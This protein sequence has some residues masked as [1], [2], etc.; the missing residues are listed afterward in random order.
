[1]TTVARTFWATVGVFVLLSQACTAEEVPPRREQYLLLNAPYVHQSQ[2]VLRYAHDKFAEA[3]RRSTLKVGVSIIYSPADKVD[4]SVRRLQTDLQL[5]RKLKVPVLIQVDTENWLPESLLNWYDPQKPGFDP[6]KVADVEWYGWTPDTAVKVCWRNW[7][8]PIRVGPHPNL[9]SPRFQAWEK[10]IYQAM[11]PVVVQWVRELPAEDQWLFVGWKC[12]WE[13]MP[14]NQYRYFRDGNSYYSRPDNPEWNDT[15]IQHI[16][17]NAARTAGIQT[18]GELGHSQLMKVVGRHLAFLSS[19]ARELGLP[20]EKLYSHSLTQE[21]DSD[22]LDVQFNS[23]SNPSP[24]YYGSSRN[25]LR[26][27]ASFMKCV[28]KAKAELGVTGY[29]Y[30]EFRLGETDHATWYR[31]FREELLADPDCVFHALYNFDTLQGQAPI[32]Q[33]LLDAM[34]TSPVAPQR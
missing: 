32:E 16:G 31:W 13:T 2:D 8:T 27:N 6:A 24:S 1:M 9:L 7:G 30:G 4:E 20:R 3:S 28:K 19:T 26:S 15:H 10:S 18:S 12:G 5:A 14:N 22:N 23:D 34:A 29:G 11:A 21:T 17:Y 33:A 25:S